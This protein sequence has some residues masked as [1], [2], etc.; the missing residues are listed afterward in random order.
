MIN[1]HII[2]INLRNIKLFWII[3]L[4]ISHLGKNPKNGGKPPRDK[5]FNVKIIFI[6]MLLLLIKNICLIEKIFMILNIIIILAE[7]IE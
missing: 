3:K 5:K 6:E 2:I 7:I 4:I 1:E